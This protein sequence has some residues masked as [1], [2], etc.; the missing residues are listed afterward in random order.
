MSQS[1]TF[2]P[3]QSH[4][5]TMTP[6]DTSMA[7][8]M[9]TPLVHTQESS[10]ATLAPTQTS[11]TTQTPMRASMDADGTSDDFCGSS[12]SPTRTPLNPLRH[13]SPSSRRALSADPSPSQAQGCRTAGRNPSWTLGPQHRDY[14]HSAASYL[15]GVPGG[16]EWNDLLASYITFESLSSARAVSVSINAS[17][18]LSNNIVIGII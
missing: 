16:P 18:S 13:T 12:P 9:S 10:T 11:T 1:P 15:A 2:T 6:D 7:M 5:R 3:L 17:S 14:V 4:G 8:Q